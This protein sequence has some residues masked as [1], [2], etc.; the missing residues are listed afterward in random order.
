MA[1][2][3]MKNYIIVQK[4]NRKP[5][6]NKRNKSKS[7]KQCEWESSDHS[8]LKSNMTLNSNLSGKMII[9]WN[10]RDDCHQLPQKMTP[11]IASTIYLYILSIPNYLSC[12]AVKFQS[13]AVHI[14][15]VCFCDCHKDEIKKEKEAAVVL[16]HT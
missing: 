10:K 14:L 12:R 13:R 2:A 7:G 16:S 6:K 8:Q 4:K 1:M 15:F 5:N 3:S 9:T 11:R